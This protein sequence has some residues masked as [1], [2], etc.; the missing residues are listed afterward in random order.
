MDELHRH[1]G[2]SVRIRPMGC[3]PDSGRRAPDQAAGHESPGIP[4]R[5]TD[6]AGPVAPKGCAR[7]DP[8][9]AKGH[10][11]QPRIASIVGRSRLRPPVAP[12]PAMIHYHVWFDLKP[13]VRES[14]GFATVARF[15][16]KLCEI[17]EAAT[18][19]ILRN[20]GGPPRSKLP[21]YHALIQFWDDAQLSDAMKNQV[22]RGIHAGL[23]GKVI[24]V[25]TD[26]HVEIF[27]RLDVQTTD[28]VL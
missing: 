20:K 15:L 11:A 24:D 25:V 10:G 6:L 18:F 5:W 22:A 3:S 8:H 23:H 14:E 2:P 4:R 28:G 12:L 13:E 19:Q 7:R 27:S 26:F 9:L 1:D 16:K 17:D 21:R